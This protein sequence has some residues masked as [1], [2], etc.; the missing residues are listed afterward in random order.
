MSTF[1]SQSLLAEQAFTVKETC[2]LGCF[3]RSMPQPRINIGSRRNFGS[4][5]L[6]IEQ[7]SSVIDQALNH[8]MGIALL[9]VDRQGDTTIL[10]EL[11]EGFA[12]YHQTG[13]CHPTKTWLL[14]CAPI[15][16]GWISLC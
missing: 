9:A 2:S 15:D 1:F 14:G 12:I 8:R 16:C 13:C 4:G 10:V 5:G 11:S 3:W 6:A 7:Q